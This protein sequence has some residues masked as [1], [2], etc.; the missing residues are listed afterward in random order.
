VAGFLKDKAV[1]VTGAGNGIGR[2]VAIA[3]AAEGAKVVVADLGVG[4]A[5][6]DPRS[7]VADAVVQEIT[8]A[9]GEAVAAADAILVDGAVALCGGATLPEARGKGAYRALLAA[10]FRDAVERGTPVLVVQAGSMSRPILERLGF[11]TV[12][13]VRVLVDRME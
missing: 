1:V 10:R 9:G 13:R 11:D 2:A 7:E 12:A 6:E 3:C 4:L 5:G 8:D